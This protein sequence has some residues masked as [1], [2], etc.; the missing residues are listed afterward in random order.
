MNNS[1]AEEGRLSNQTRTSLASS[2]TGIQA[3]QESEVKIATAL[4]QKREK[5][6]EWVSYSKVQCHSIRKAVFQWDSHDTQTSTGR[7]GSRRQRP[8]TGEVTEQQRRLGNSESGE[9]TSIGASEHGVNQAQANIPEPGSAS[10]RSR[11]NSSA[12]IASGASATTPQPHTAANLNIT[13]QPMDITFFAASTP[14]VLEAEKLGVQKQE[15]KEGGG[16]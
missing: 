3:T 1:F 14:T 4:A 8:I 13:S 16:A 2:D 5:H 6:K 15:D 10:R 12:S 7:G 11:S 9:E